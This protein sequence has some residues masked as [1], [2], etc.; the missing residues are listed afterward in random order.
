VPWAPELFSAP[1]VARLEE[2]L[3]HKLATVPYFA[4]LLSG[5]IDAMK[6]SFV[7]EPEVHDP[8]RGHVKGARPF[9]AYVSEVKAWLEEHT[10]WFSTSTARAAQ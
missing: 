10:R 7:G 6:D 4:G 9:A 5:E 8:V 3:Q 2:E 1:V